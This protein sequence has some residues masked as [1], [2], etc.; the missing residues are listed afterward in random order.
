MRK[1]LL[2]AVALAYFPLVAFSQPSGVERSVPAP[3]RSWTTSTTWE[4]RN[5]L[6]S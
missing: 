6:R 4:P 2:P 3:S 5:W 1:L